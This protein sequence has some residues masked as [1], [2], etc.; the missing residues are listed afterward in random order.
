MRHFPTDQRFDN[1]SDCFDTSVLRRCLIYIAF[2]FDNYYIQ[3][4]HKN[5]ISYRFR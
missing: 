1:R 3:I 4:E 2:L 5:R